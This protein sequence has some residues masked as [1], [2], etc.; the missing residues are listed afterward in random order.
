MNSHGGA[1]YAPSVTIGR[2]AAETAGLGR[3][4]GLA[5]KVTPIGLSLPVRRASSMIDFQNASYFKISQVDLGQVADRIN[6]LLI[7]GEQAFVAYKACATMSSS[8]VSGSSR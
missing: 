4:D 2:C 7:E 8:R 6:P 5:K 1:Q 3:R